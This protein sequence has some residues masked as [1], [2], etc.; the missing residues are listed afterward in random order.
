M[1]RAMATAG[2]W[3]AGP[4]VSTAPG[5]RAVMYLAVSTG[6]RR[7][8]VGCSTSVGVSMSANVWRTSASTASRMTRTSSTQCSMSV[9]GGRSEGVRQ[10]PPGRRGGR[11]FKTG[12]LGEYGR[13]QRS[14]GGARF[15]TEFVAEQPPDSRARSA[16][17][18][19]AR[20]VAAL[21]HRGCRWH[22][23]RPGPAGHAPRTGQRQAL[24]ARAASGTRAAP[25]AAGDPP[26]P[27]VWAGERST[28]PANGPC[29]N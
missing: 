5:I 28:G 26:R 13:L 15:H 6:T 29:L 19:P 8:P 18:T 21:R 2:P 16:S 22:R 24:R 25:I 14:Q 4:M 7:S 11:Q 10:H 1:L 17:T 9:S 20:G 23:H 3:R 12:V 27:E